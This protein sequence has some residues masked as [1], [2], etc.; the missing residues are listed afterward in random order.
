MG[1]LFLDDGSLVQD[2]LD[3]DVPVAQV[4]EGYEHQ[5]V[6]VA[7][8]PIDHEENLLGLGTEYD[9]LLASRHRVRCRYVGSRTGYVRGSDTQLNV[10]TATVSGDDYNLDTTPLDDMNGDHVL[11][12]YIGGDGTLPVITH[13]L[14]HPAS[15]LPENTEALPEEERGDFVT[16]GGVTIR[17]LNSGGV[18]VDAREGGAAQRIYLRADDNTDVVL[19]SGKVVVRGPEVEAGSGGA[20]RALATEV[21]ADDLALLTSLLGV[22]IPAAAGFNPALATALAAALPGSPYGT[23]TATLAALVAKAGTNYKTT[24]LKGE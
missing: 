9:V 7:K 13:R 5:G 22:I 21:S 3:N 19:E 2:G 6:V 24:V 4:E 17:L 16:L 11:V 12:G 20:V 8:Y 23:G 10:T 1:G 18:L 14:P 15:S